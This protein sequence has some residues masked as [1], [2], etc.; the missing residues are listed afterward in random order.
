MA[1]I[2]ATITVDFI[3]NYVGDHRI[4]WRIQGSG[5]PYDCSTIVNCVGGGAA[6]QGIITADVNTTSCDGDVTFEGYVQSGC[7]TEVSVEGRIP[8]SAL[9]T[10]T[11]VCVRN[12]VKCLFGD[13]IDL[14]ASNIGHSYEVTDTF[15]V[16]RVVGDGQVSDA[17]ITI[18]TVGDGIILSVD[19]LLNQGINYLVAD[20]LDIVDG[21]GAGSGAQITVDTVGGSGEI[22]TFTLTA[23]GTDYVGNLTLTGGTGTGAV[24]DFVSYKVFGS[25]LS[26]TI[27][28]PGSYEI[29]PIVTITTGTGSNF[30]VTSVLKDCIQLIGAYEDCDAV[31]TDVPVMPVGDFYNACLLSTLVVPDRHTFTPNG[32]CIA[33]DSVDPVCVEYELLNASGVPINGFEYT[34]CNGVT[35]SV[36][37]PFSETPTV[38]CAV[39]GGIYN[40]YPTEDLLVT[41]TGVPCS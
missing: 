41:N 18:D 36:N 3:A 11:V 28:V 30:A 39:I 27:T 4:C 2:T 26:Y 16:T 29:P 19:P 24:L 21:V 12:E 14:D 17:S 5:D 35:T 22:L 37:I 31:P 40:P 23:P 9:F 34:G 7:E 8:W 1:I 10:P 20:V 32:C 33:A 25:V 15:V 38:V 13:L 6:C